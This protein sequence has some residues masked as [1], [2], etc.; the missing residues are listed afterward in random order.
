VLYT[1]SLHDALPIFGLAVEAVHLDQDLVERLLALVVAAADPDA[2]APPDRVD[3]VDEDDAGRLLARLG[4]Q[5]ADA[6]GADADEHLD[7]RSEEHTSELQ[8]PYD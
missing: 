2:A 8:S 7:E 5:V 3:L 4:E 1:L 6:A